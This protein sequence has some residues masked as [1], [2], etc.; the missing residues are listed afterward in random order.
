MWLFIF[1]ILNL[2]LI[3]KLKIKNIVL[4]RLIDMSLVL[5][6]EPSRGH[7]VAGD[8]EELSAAINDLQALLVRLLSNF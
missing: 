4:F 3:I 8:A 2:I 7:N 6:L 1:I 5:S